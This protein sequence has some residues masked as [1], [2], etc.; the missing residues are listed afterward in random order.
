MPVP[1]ALL[2]GLNE[3]G[4]HQACAQEL[5][6][7]YFVW[8]PTLRSPDPASFTL[9]PMTFPVSRRSR[10]LRLTPSASLAV[11]LTLSNKGEDAYWV[12]LSLGFP[13]GLS[14]RKVEMLKVSEEAGPAG[15]PARP[16]ASAAPGHSGGQARAPRPAEVFGPVWA[17]SPMATLRLCGLRYKVHPL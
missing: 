10:V 1:A 3:A 7:V 2:S 14:F 4:K 9:T 13:R 16:A 12:Q 6:W 17:R 5:L 11:E 8:A 15:F